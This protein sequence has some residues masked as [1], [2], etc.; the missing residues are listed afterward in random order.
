M[1]LCQTVMTGQ[2]LVFQVIMQN[3]SHQAGVR[4]NQKAT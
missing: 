1:Q 2:F 3:P 4:G